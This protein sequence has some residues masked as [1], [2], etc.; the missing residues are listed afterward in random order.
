[1][2]GSFVVVGEIGSKP[3]S[4][5]RFEK[6]VPDLLKYNPTLML[7]TGG[8]VEDGT[9]QNYRQVYAVLERINK[10]YGVAVE[11]TPGASDRHGDKLPDTYRGY[12]GEPTASFTWNG[13]KFI[14]LDSSSGKLENK[15]LEFL[16]KHLTVPSFIFTH[17]PPAEGLWKF[18]GLKEG[19]ERLLSILAE[20]ANLIQGC[21]FGHLKA[22]HQETLTSA[23]MVLTFPAY[24]VGN[25]G[26][27]SFEISKFGYSRAGKMGGLAGLMRGGGAPV[28]ESIEVEVGQD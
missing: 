1:M 17:F 11:V 24:V 26:V 2:D 27:E 23:G 6:M 18:D 28:F 21:F 14:T 4:L 13:I 9:D 7:V 25:A 3:G 5:D 22:C 19:T 8:L 10:R 20:R 12:F 15:Q 16:E